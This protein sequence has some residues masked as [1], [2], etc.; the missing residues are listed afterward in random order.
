[1]TQ[2][3]PGGG[4]EASAP[5]KVHQSILQSIWFL[6]CRGRA[7]L[8]FIGWAHLS[9][10]A[11]FYVSLCQS[12]SRALTLITGLTGKIQVFVKPAFQLSLPLQLN[13][14]LFECLCKRLKMAKNS[15]SLVRPQK[16]EGL[17]IQPRL[18][19]IDRVSNW[20]RSPLTSADCYGCPSLYCLARVF[21]NLPGPHKHYGV[22]MFLLMFFFFNLKNWGSQLAMSTDDRFL[23]QGSATH[24][25]DRLAYV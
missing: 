8:I 10:P 23:P 25:L 9:C 2:A 14:C 17:N 6:A 5:S 1:M 4:I 7:V 24:N 13:V 20:S 12:T 22:L 21:Q 19:L 15:S 18:F 11:Y 3:K 16:R